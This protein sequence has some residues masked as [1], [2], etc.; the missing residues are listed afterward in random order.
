MRIQHH[1]S[2][3]R[4]ALLAVASFF[5]MSGCVSPYLKIQKDRSGFKDSPT[6]LSAAV[7][8]NSRESEDKAEKPNLLD[9]TLK[10]VSNVQLDEVGAAMI[11]HAS[12]MLKTYGFLVK[13]DAKRAKKLDL[14]TGKT[15]EALNKAGQVLGGQWISQDG[16]LMTRITDQTWLLESYRKS[17]V[18]K[19]NSD[20]PNEHFLF[21]SARCDAD[22]EWI[23]FSRPE[24]V[25]YYLLLD[26][27]GKIVFEARGIGHGE[28]SL[29][30][31][32]QSPGNLM[33]ALER[34]QAN[35]RAQKP[36][37]LN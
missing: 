31:D 33:T 8:D 13:T 5:V 29:F 26:E 1:N 28:N 24:V 16:S 30:T 37:I 27:K 22:R 2:T 34:A 19:L 32:D 14:L 35:M 6:L 11:E 23:I 36:K 18:D 12:K 10:V 20:A 9:V 25:L 3:L 15:M 17:L 21:I 4:W 7:F